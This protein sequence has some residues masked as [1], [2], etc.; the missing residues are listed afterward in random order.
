[1][2]RLTT[3]GSTVPAGTN[4]ITKMLDA[5]FVSEHEARL[6]PDI[7]L[8][9]IGVKISLPTPF[10][11]TSTF[12]E[13]EGWVAQLLGWFQM[14]QLDTTSSTH[15]KLWIQILG[16]MLKGKALKQF[17]NESEM[18]Q[19]ALRTLDFKDIIL[20]LQDRFY[21]NCHCSTNSK[22]RLLVKDQLRAMIFE[23]ERRIHGSTTSIYNKSLCTIVVVV[24]RVAASR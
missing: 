3:P 2:P 21:R 7:Q 6:R 24:L 23:L 11:G 1:M 20:N 5:A 12:E 15:D 8:A 18:A 19:R 14:Y 13:F 9:K 22:R 4:C 16:Q 17:T 10:E